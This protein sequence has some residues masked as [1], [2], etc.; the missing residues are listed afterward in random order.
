MPRVM[1]FI[2]GPNFAHESI[3]HDEHLQ[4]DFTALADALVKRIGSDATYEGTFY[5]C[6]IIPG[7]GLKDDADK[8]RLRKREGFLEALQY[9]RGYTVKKRSKV[10]RSVT[11]EKCSETTS[12]FVEKGVDVQIATD[13]MSFGVRNGYD[14][15]V[16]VSNDGDLAPAVEFL[17]DHG[18]KVYHAQFNPRS[19]RNLGKACFDSIDLAQLKDTIKR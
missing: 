1:I 5:Y 17:R 4:V 3:S 2:D 12:A 16:L 18:K 19:G 15:A 13:M 8:E 7:Y 11:C 10:R 9:K 14:V 6:S